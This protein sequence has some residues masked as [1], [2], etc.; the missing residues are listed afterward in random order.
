MS[1]PWLDPRCYESLGKGRMGLHKAGSRR[2]V[3]SPQSPDAVARERKR[4]PGVLYA[5]L[6]QQ[7]NSQIGSDNSSAWH[8][9]DD[10]QPPPWDSCRTPKPNFLTMAL[11]VQS[12]R[13]V[14]KCG[15]EASPFFANCHTCTSPYLHPEGALK[16]TTPSGSSKGWGHA[17][18]VETG[19]EATP[20]PRMTGPSRTHLQNRVR[21][22]PCEGL[23]R[24][25]AGSF[26]ISMS[27]TQR[28]N[29]QPQINPRCIFNAEP[30]AI[31]RHRTEALP[32]GVRLQ[33]SGT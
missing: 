5:A 23:I 3:T 14:L 31:L 4:I 25:S 32:L 18:G 29:K 8:D 1:R 26:S 2:A 22:P 21:S 24:G 27:L 9:S 7:K 6:S 10:V 28:F 19:S 16:G 33:G 20:G 13:D 12:R 15:S 11:S 17:A 30:P